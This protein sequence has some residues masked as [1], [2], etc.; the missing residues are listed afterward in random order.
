M[1]CKLRP[2]KR[3]RT[4]PRFLWFSRGAS[5]ASY[6]IRN[7]FG[8]YLHVPVRPP[9][10]SLYG[11]F[12]IFSFVIE[13]IVNKSSIEEQKGFS[14]LLFCSFQFSERTHLHEIF[15]GLLC[16]KFG[17]SRVVW[18]WKVCRPSMFFYARR[19]RI[20][21]GVFFNFL[22]VSFNDFCS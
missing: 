19:S 11:L 20:V 14:S 17:K 2:R 4:Q 12:P 10:S 22:C 16:V 3:L 1:R 18:S 8:L 5:T 13:T 6:I 15:Q 21:V 9:L 7:D